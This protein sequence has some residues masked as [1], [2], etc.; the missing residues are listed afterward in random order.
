MNTD[1]GF[2]PRRSREL[3]RSWVDD[4]LQTSTLN[5]ARI[6]VAPQD[7]EDDTDTGL[8]IMRPKGSGLSVYMQPRGFDD[9]LWELTIPS[10]DYDVTMSAL[11]LG[12]LAS[13]VLDAARLCTYLQFRSLEWDRGSGRHRTSS[14]VGVDEE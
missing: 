6:D 13:V 4:Y 2:P 9:P 1:A 5:G 10:R 12:G 3:L 11:E 7:A 8:V 14:H